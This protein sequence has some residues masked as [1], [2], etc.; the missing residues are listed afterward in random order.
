MHRTNIYDRMVL[1]EFFRA[2]FSQ[3]EKVPTE[4]ETLQKV[5]IEKEITY[6]LAQ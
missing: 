1:Q 2:F 4:K 6:I 3:M 5:H